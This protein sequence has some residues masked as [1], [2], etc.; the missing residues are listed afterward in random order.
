MPTYRVLHTIIPGAENG[1]MEDPLHYGDH[2]ELTERQA[3]YLLQEGIIEP[4]S[5]PRAEEV[6]PDELSE[7]ERIAISE[8][9]TPPVKATKRSRA[10]RAKAQRDELEEQQQQVGKE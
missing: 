1:V 4:E 7:E 3:E 5:A 8:D 10:A 9:D 6:D 2:I